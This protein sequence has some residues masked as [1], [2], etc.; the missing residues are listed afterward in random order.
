MGLLRGWYGMIF[1]PLFMLLLPALVTAVAVPRVRWRGGAWQGTLP[2]R[3]APLDIRR[4]RFAR[5]E[6]DKEEFQERRRM[7]G[8]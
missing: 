6:I 1:R 3:R 4:E 2:L 8:G 5:G 7:L